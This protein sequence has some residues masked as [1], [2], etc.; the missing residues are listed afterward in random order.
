MSFTLASKLELLPI[1]GECQVTRARK[2]SACIYYVYACICICMYIFSFLPSGFPFDH[3]R[4]AI[5]PFLLPMFRILRVWSISFCFTGL[6]MRLL[7]FVFLI[8]TYVI[9]VA[10]KHVNY[11]FGT[12]FQQQFW[13]ALRG[14]PLSIFG[15][16]G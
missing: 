14:P 6:L 5:I 15:N 10:L 13:D 8:P 11:E 12:V 2:A 16:A 3:Q 7:V 1:L 9:C 4:M